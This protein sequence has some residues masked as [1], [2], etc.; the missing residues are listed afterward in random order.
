MPFYLKRIDAGPNEADNGAGYE[1]AGA[2]PA[3]RKRYVVRSKVVWERQNRHEQAAAQGEADRAPSERVESTVRFLPAG[4]V[5]KGEIRFHNLHPVELGALLWALTF[6]EADN[7]ARP[8]RHLLGRAKARGFGALEAH[9]A[10]AISTVVAPVAAQPGS[11][12]LPADLAAYLACFESYMASKLGIGPKRP[13]RELPPVRNLRRLANAKIGDAAF[14][15]GRLDE[16]RV[17]ED[18]GDWRREGRQEGRN[19]LADLGGRE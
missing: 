18:F 5:F 19:L 11:P 16:G 15:E 10:L 12:G 3:G 8:Y 6:G 14:V 17:K 13:F 4:T 9:V 1:D 2:V 7:S